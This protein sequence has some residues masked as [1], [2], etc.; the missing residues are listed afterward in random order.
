M[1]IDSR[2]GDA[3]RTSH[4]LI[5]DDD[6]STAREVGSIL[7]RAGVPSLHAVSIPQALEISRG[8]SLRAM[9]LSSTISRLRPEKLIRILREKSSSERVAILVIA[10]RRVPGLEM[11]C[12]IGGADDFLVRAGNDLTTIPLRLAR[13]G[14]SLTTDATIIERGIIRV[15][16]DSR[17]TFVA[18]CLVP[19][20]RPREFDLL[21]YLMRRSPAVARWTE[22][23][24]EVWG[25]PEHALARGRQTKTISVHCERL[26]RRLGGAATLTAR[27]GVGLQFKAAERPTSDFHSPPANG[28]SIGACGFA[29]A[30]GARR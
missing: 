6:P 1:K 27:R 3:R 5:I 9:I 30:P 15:D 7:T 12:L 26:R 20:I 23:Q 28:T 13:L 4:V 16:A 10:T 14:A 29:R 25:T 22:I 19:D 11:R 24:R 21:V 18:G 17:E 8:T 2:V